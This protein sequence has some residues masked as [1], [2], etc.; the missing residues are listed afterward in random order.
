MRRAWKR[1]AR[2]K[3]KSKIGSNLE[4]QQPAKGG[5]TLSWTQTIPPI[6]FFAIYVA[7]SNLV[8]HRRIR[9][10]KKKKKRKSVC[11]Y[12]Q[13]RPFLKVNTHTHSEKTGT[14]IDN[15]FAFPVQLG[16]TAQRIHQNMRL[17]LERMTLSERDYYPERN[18]PRSRTKFI[19]FKDTIRQHTCR[20]SLKETWKVV[21]SIEKYFQPRA[22][23]LLEWNKVTIES[24]K[25]LGCAPENK[26][27]WVKKKLCSGC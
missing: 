21:S 2:K 11:N 8:Q 26:M 22:K 16:S 9:T 13:N 7:K 12:N 1:K 19:S 23:E 10:Y 18:T 17:V 20:E 5:T 14:S 27:W 6:P 15:N 24:A 25:S 4:T 3:H